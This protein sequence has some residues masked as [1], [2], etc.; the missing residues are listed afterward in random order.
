MTPNT[1]HGFQP[2]MKFNTDHHFIYIIA[3][4]DEQKEQL[5]SYYKLKEEDLEDITKEW[6]VDLLI[7]ADPVEMSDINSPE[8]TQDTPRPSKTKKTKNMKKVE[9]FQ[10]IDS[11]SVRT[12][13]T[14]LDQ[15]GDGKDL[16]EVEQRLEDELEIINKRK[17]LPLEPSS[18]KKSK[19]PVTKLQTTLTPDDF[20]FLIAA[21]NEA[22]EEIAEKQEV[23]QETMYNGIEIDLQGM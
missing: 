2:L 17:G 15:G 20:S 14:T 3:C 8:A 1:L 21:M 16:E 23:K 6:S 18:R 7:S 19:A 10:D 4:I 5:Q 11:L 22:L 13:S 12:D 9:E